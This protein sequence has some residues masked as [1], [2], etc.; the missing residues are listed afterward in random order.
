VP[1]KMQL[2]LRPD[3]YFKPN[4]SFAQSIPFVPSAPVEAEKA[5][6]PAPTPFSMDFITKFNLNAPVFKPVN[7]QPVEYEQYVAEPTPAAKK[8]K[9]K[10]K[11][12]DKDEQKEENKD[13]STSQPA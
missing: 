6:D 10:K 5:K 3:T 8:K 4:V 11:N 13:E 12:K 7:F 9:K 2:T 1:E